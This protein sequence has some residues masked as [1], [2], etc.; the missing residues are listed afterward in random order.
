MGMDA[1]KK[2]RVLNR[3]RPA[4]TPQ[5][6]RGDRQIV[7]PMTQEQFDDCWHDAAKM[8]KLV[9]R[10]QAENPELFPACL[11]EGYAFHGFARPSQKCDGIRL[12]KIRSRDGTQAYHL[13]PSFVMSYMTGTTDEL[14]YP[15]LLASFGVPNWV[16]TMG[17]GHSDMYWHRLVERIGRNSLVGTTV[18]DPKRLPEHLAAD[19]HHVDW[20]GEKGYVATTAAEDCILGIAV[21]KMA[22][23]EHL[24]AAYGVFAA[25]AR[26]V[27]PT[28][29]PKTVNTDGWAA[30]QNAFKACFCGIVVILCFL[31][32]FL[33]IRDRCRK[34]RALHKRVWEVYW[35]KTATEFRAAMTAFRAWFESQTWT[36]T[37]REMV[38]KLWKRTE[39]YVVAYDYPGCRRTSNAVD[40][41]MNRLCRLMYAGRGL[42][43]HQASSERRLRGWALLL[44]FRPFAK[45]SGQVRKERSR[46]HRLN[47]KLYS[48]N[49]LE[50]LQISASLMGRNHTAPAI[51]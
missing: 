50:N 7:L 33:K 41:P 39:D 28:Y 31:H 40:R 13:R 29:A 16:L 11:R 32:G 6:Q 4:D 9:D 35:T 49:W 26:E 23:D 20:N 24:T 14:E 2:A 44:N 19:E 34:N 45:R 17:F 27:D 8:R 25:E 47:G 30:T 48:E 42:H 15:L 12:R 51:R 43:G 22:D 5:S 46:A 10:L 3:N 21:T 36:Q 38:E 1:A 37:I 18:R